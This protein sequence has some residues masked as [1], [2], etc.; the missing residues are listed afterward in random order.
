MRAE[1]L[2]V[3]APGLRLDRFLA[4]RR[5]AYSRS[6][7]RFLIEAGA[8][9]VDD[10]AR[11]ADFRLKGGETLR[12]AALQRDWAEEPDFERWVLHEDRQLLVLDKPAGL[13][14]HPLG[15]S[16]LNSP[17]AALSERQPNLAGILQRARP[18][19][20][21]LSRCGI[22]HRL[23]RQTSGAL[24]VAKTAAAQAALLEDFKRRRVSKIYRAI[25]R[26]APGRGGR[27]EAPIGR[28]PGHRKVLVTPFG[29]SAETAF[30]V[31]EA[32]PR[33]ALVEAR[34]LTGRTHQIR[35]HLAFV[36]HPVAGDVEFDAG[37]SPRPPR[38]MLHA[39]QIA[40]RHPGSGR[41]V[42]FRAPLPD[43]FKSFWSACRS[44]G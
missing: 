28:K 32:C 8:V 19:L 14:M 10:R 34:P 22:V 26:G 36:G 43:D 30:S 5:P 39:Y 7:W 27:V 20:A 29:K 3:D 33:A 38:L 17:A 23:D 2:T 13:L 9:T 6:H 15:T 31:L 25:V 40:L 44:A 35:A 42:R 4:L 24:L 21:G 16:W 41:S 12:V 11:A 1:R 18:A 37:G